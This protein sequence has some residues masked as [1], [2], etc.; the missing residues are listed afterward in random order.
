MTWAAREGGEILNIMRRADR[1]HVDRNDIETSKAAQKLQPLAR[2]QPAS[3]RW[4]IDHQVSARARRFPWLKG[5]SRHP[6]KKT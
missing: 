1:I 6:T 5:L 4:V 2:R 3:A